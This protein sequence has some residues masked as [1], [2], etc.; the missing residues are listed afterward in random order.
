MALERMKEIEISRLRQFKI[1]VICSSIALIII[2]I[3]IITRET[4]RQD[5]KRYQE[6]YLAIVGHD[7]QEETDIRIRQIENADLQIADRC[8]T[9]HIGLYDQRMEEQPQPLTLHPGSWLSTHDP[10]IFGCSVCHGGRGRALETRH[11]HDRAINN[12]FLESDQIN[13][14]CGKCHLAVFQPDFEL[15]GAEDLVA[16]RMIFIKK[17]CQGCH[18]LRGVGGILGPDLTGLGSRTLHSFDFRAVAG[19]HT[20]SDWQRAHL[21]HPQQITSGSIMPTFFLPDKDMQHLILFLQGLFRPEFP[22]QYLAL[23]VIREF[24][25]ERKEIASDQLF[26]RFCSGCHGSAGKN[27]STCSVPFS[28]P[29]LSNHDFQ[30]VA[31]LDFIAFT[32]TE[33]RSDRNMNAWTGDISGMRDSEIREIINVV[34]NMRSAGTDVRNIRAGNGNPQAGQKIFAENCA[35][36]HAAGDGMRMA[37]NILSDG[38][39]DLASDMYIIRNIVYGR[40]NTAMPSWRDFSGAALSDLLA[41]IRSGQKNSL[42]TPVSVRLTGSIS[43]GDSIFHYTCSRCHGED[44]AGGIGPAILNNA[45]LRTTNPGFT[46]ATITSGRIHTAMFGY[47][48]SGGAHHPEQSK[49]IEDI[50]TYMYSRADSISDHIPTGMVLG[51]PERGKSI[52]YR[53]CTECHG[54]HGE[55]GKGPALNN[56]EFLNAASN[57]YLI[58]TISL[59]R[60]G[61]EMPSW[62]RGQTDYPALTPQERWDVVARIREWQTVRIIRDRKWVQTGDERAAPGTDQQIQ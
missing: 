33:G 48:R 42:R 5:W 7:E 8:P 29:T 19:P 11:A 4:G 39:L 25:N 54:Q 51:D 59:G 15:P 46:A 28:V 34:R 31:S 13:A 27:D 47:G 41:F 61:T 18:K 35:M 21:Q 44:G 37:P 49:D 57:G 9:C 58:A 24:K 10:E 53:R 1:T 62:G 40:P 16:G 45:F 30:A 55:G 52:F 36:C 17:G 38:F 60:R 2:M 50:V 20:I 32:I 26:S 14:Y 43:R 6:D 56:Q 23:P 3:L 22:L 12:P